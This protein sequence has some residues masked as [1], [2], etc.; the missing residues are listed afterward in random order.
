MSHA[1]RLTERDA[2]I[3]LNSVPGIGETIL[4]VLLAQFRAAGHVL[5]AARD[6]TLQAW[7]RLARRSDN[8]PWLDADVVSA[9]IQAADD[10]D[11]RLRP[12]A[13]LSLWTLTAL[14]SDYPQ[15]LRDL[16]PP[17]AVIHGLGNRALL[18][19]ERTVAIVG[20][21]RPTPA[22]RALTSKVSVRVGEAGA[23]VVSGLAVGIDGVAHA[24]AVDRGKPTIGVIGAGHLQPGPR[25]HARLRDEIIATGGALISEHHPEAHATRGTYPRRNRIISALGDATVVVEAPRT[26]GAIITANHALGLG[27]NVYVAPGR[28]GDWSVE[29]SLKLLRETPAKPIAGIE[30]LIEDLGYYG[31]A[32]VRESSPLV[33][34]EAAL[35]MLGPTER[36]VASRLCVSPAG[37][38]ALVADTGLPPGA[39]SSA[40]TLLLMRGWVQTAGP[41]YIAASPLAK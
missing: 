37:L 7:N 12:I 41:A 5:D 21:R 22:G 32:N 20:T 15:R 30:E 9:L 1:E 29:G 39:I 16:D 19:A 6:G 11:S 38:D 26:S 17:P 8:R 33:A 27:R 24:A 28:I 36:A 4:G 3:V 31:D 14:D 13:D 25:A 23:V 2:W 10:P 40:V 35:K 18:D 34:K